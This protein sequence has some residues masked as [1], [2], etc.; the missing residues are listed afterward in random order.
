MGDLLAERVIQYPVTK[1]DK[2]DHVTFS[3]PFFGDRGKDLMTNQC[4]C[5]LGL[6]FG[7]EASYASMINNSTT[8]HGDSSWLLLNDIVKGWH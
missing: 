2:Q 8:T 4:F 1:A 6:G 3:H 5:L 7:Q